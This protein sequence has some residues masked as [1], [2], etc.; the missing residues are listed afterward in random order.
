VGSPPA[1]AAALRES[2]FEDITFVRISA[3]FSGGVKLDLG[4]GGKVKTWLESA[5]DARCLRA[6]APGSA[7]DRSATA[8]ALAYGACNIGGLF[9]WLALA[10]VHGW[11]CL[12]QGFLGSV[13][14]TIWR[15]GFGL[16]VEGQTL[17]ARQG[18]GDRT[19]PRPDVAPAQREPL[20]T[21][22]TATRGLPGS[23]SPDYGG[24]WGSTS[25]GA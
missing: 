11:L 17:P 19:R 1:R 4:C 18:R 8:H 21:A 2:V 6:W 22:Q 9:Q 24:R 23:V 25:V 12:S 13:L 7:D 5:A 14:G 3:S 20:I 16:S 15:P 10:R